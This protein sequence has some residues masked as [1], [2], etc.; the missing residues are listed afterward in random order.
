MRNVFNYSIKRV[1]SEIRTL[2][3]HYWPSDRLSTSPPPSSP[4]SSPFPKLSSRQAREESLGKLSSRKGERKVFG[5]K[6]KVSA[7]IRNHKWKVLV[8]KVEKLAPKKKFPNHKK[9]PY[10]IGF[11]TFKKKLLGC[12]TNF[13]H[14]TFGDEIWKTIRNLEFR[15]AG[16]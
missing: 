15:R 10:L 16:S 13:G 7:P 5:P 12:Q 3:D 11:L 2:I 4:P 8:G 9:Q 14:A 1:T 6:K